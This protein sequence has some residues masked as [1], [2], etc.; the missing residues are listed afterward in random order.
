MIANRIR[1]WIK[2]IRRL[3]LSSSTNKLFCLFIF[4]PLEVGH[5]SKIQLGGL[6]EASLVPKSDLVHFSLKICNLAATI[7]VIFH[8]CNF[9]EVVCFSHMRDFS[10][11]KRGHK[12]STLNGFSVFAIVIYYFSP[13]R[14]L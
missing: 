14:V 5:L 7:L 3:G 8:C 13:V 10:F 11:F 9:S 1:G 4:L 6:R 12:T 2:L